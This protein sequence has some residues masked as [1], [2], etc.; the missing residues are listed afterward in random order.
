M[1]LEELQTIIEKEYSRPIRLEKT[2]RAR[3]ESPHEF[4]ISFFTSWNCEK[5]TLYA[6]DNTIQTGAAKRRSLGDIFMICK[7]YYPEITLAEVIYELYIALKEHFGNGYR[8]SYCHML[9]KRVWYF[10]ADRKNLFYDKTKYDEYGK[11]YRYYLSFFLQDDLITDTDEADDDD[12]DE[13]DDDDY[14]EDDD[15]YI[16]DT[17]CDCGFC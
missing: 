10:D 3:K 13:P 15:I 2:K 12:L 17:V 8:T 1:K 4:L 11:P 9:N 7:Y 14:D 5:N 6:D 16:E